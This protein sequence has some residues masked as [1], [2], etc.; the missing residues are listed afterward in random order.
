M[1][2]PNAIRT[3][4]TAAATSAPAKT[5]VH[6]RKDVVVPTATISVCSE[7]ATLVV[8]SSKGGVQRRPRNDRMKRITTIRPMR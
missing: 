2:V 7:I 3:K 1:T 6:C 8:L 4:E 5:G